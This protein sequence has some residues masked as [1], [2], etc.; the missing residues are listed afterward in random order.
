MN[1]K[2]RILVGASGMLASLLILGSF[3][4]IA[5]ARWYPGDLFWYDGGWQGLVWML[6]I[7][8]VAGGALSFSV[9]KENKKEQA[10]DLSLIALLE[11]VL[12]GGFAMLLWQGHPAALVLDGK[13]M[14]SVDQ[15][16]AQ[17]E[18]T[19]KKIYGGKGQ[20]PIYE[21]KLPSNPD[22]RLAIARKAIAENKPFYA[23]PELWA[24]LGS[25]RGELGVADI[26]DPSQVMSADG[27]K[28]AE[29][30][31]KTKTSRDAIAP[32]MLLYGSGF[33]I[34]DRENGEVSKFVK[35]N[36]GSPV[37]YSLGGQ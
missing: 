24:P 17:K 28:V 37:L 33:L 23:M 22:K 8:A 13:L 11:L 2:S 14:S 5:A 31:L 30:I 7:L 21:V 3:L 1:L 9:V 10:A 34:I 26:K 4:W 12:A 20:L 16:T 35:A 6:P 25:K 36:I 15:K 27:A 32:A 19:W 18:V 29:G